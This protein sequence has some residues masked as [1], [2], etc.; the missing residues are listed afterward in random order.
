MTLNKPLNDG[1]LKPV[2]LLCLTLV[3]CSGT[4]FLQTHSSL[5]TILIHSNIICEKNI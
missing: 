5:V 1:G 4:K 3:R 2:N